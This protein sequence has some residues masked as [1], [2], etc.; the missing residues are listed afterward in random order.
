MSN[1]SN[2]LGVKE[3]LLNEAVARFEDL[4][5]FPSE[6]IRL[7]AETERRVRQRTADLGLDHTTPK[8]PNYTIPF[9]LNSNKTAHIWTKKSV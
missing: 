9:W 6:D 3:D 7:L 4:S 2:L 5:G 1:L 8:V